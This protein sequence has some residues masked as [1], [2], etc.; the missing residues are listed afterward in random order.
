MA[1]RVSYKVL[2]IL[3][4]AAC[5]AGLFFAVCLG[6]TNF[7]PAQ[8]ANTIIYNT[9]LSEIFKATAP[10]A[11]EINMIW[12]LRLPRVLLGFIVGAAL[13]VCG[14]CMQTLV[15]NKLADPFVLGVSSSASATASLFMVFGMF[16]FLGEYALPLSAFI[17]AFLSI[18]FVYSISKVN[19]CTNTTQLLLAGVVVSMIMDAA[20]SFIAMASPNAFSMKNV[21]FWLSGS[22]QGAKWGYLALPA[23]TMIIYTLFLLT[24]YRG[25]NALSLGTEAAVSLGINVSALEKMLFFIASILAG[26]AISVSGSIGFVGMIV[27]HLCRSLVGADHKRLLPLCVL[28]GGILVVWADVAARTIAAPDELPVGIM[29]AIV[30][31]PIFLV[32][33]KSSAPKAGEA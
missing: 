8:V 18:L 17:G 29:T 11:L 26:V 27:P 12:K 14:V 13:S 32:I 33:L 9:I 20:T 25:L 5:A 16:S 24:Q 28:F 3:G 30:G 31:A 22:L 7:S 1:R 19:G 4:A 6:S 23:V 2:I 15:K 10:T 21:T